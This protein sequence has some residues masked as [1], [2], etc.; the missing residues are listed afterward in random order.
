MFLTAQ[1]RS[2]DKR[3]SVKEVVV[4]VRVL[5]DE[6]RRPYFVTIYHH[7]YTLSYRRRPEFNFRLFRLVNRRVKSITEADVPT[8]LMNEFVALAKRYFLP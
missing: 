1:R 8:K 2:V 5:R 3:K 4:R 6:K 7:E